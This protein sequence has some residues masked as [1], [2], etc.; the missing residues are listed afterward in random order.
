MAPT[1]KKKQ[2]KNT[3]KHDVLKVNGKLLEARNYLSIVRVS[4]NDDAVQLV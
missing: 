3:I 2:H 4:E 1:D